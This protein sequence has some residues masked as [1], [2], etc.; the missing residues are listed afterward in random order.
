MG[1]LLENKVGKRINK[2]MFTASCF[3]LKSGHDLV[4]IFVV[5]YLIFMF[6]VVK[7]LNLIIMVLWYKK[8]TSTI[9]YLVTFLYR[10][11][12]EICG[13]IE[14]SYWSLRSVLNICS[15]QILWNFQIWQVFAHI[16]V[17]FFNPGKKF[18]RAVECSSM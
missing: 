15:K 3:T 8:K 17:D 14:R 18:K 5:A 7:I 12:N 13:I 16:A 9:R 1:D 10:W 2:F 11:A 4:W 6:C